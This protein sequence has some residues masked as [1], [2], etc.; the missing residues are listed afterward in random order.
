MKYLDKHALLFANIVVSTPSYDL[1]FIYHSHQAFGEAV[2]N[3]G[4]ALKDNADIPACTVIN[5]TGLKLDFKPGEY[6]QVN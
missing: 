6:Y 5:K 1:L 4:E 2:K 3:P